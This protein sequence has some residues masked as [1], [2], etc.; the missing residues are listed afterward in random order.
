MKK[1]YLVKGLIGCVIFV[2][3]IWGKVLYVQRVHFMKAEEYYKTAEW[4]LA[5]REYDFAMHAYSPWSPYIEK[6]AERLWAI[7][8]IY[9]KED[10]PYWAINAFS[11]IRSSFY[12]SRSL[13][14]PGK[15]WID[16]CENK[17]AGLDVKI[18]IGEGDLRPEDAVSEEAK[19]LYLMKADREP[20]PLWAVLV[21][22]SFFGWIASVL[23]TI[24]RGFDESGKLKFRQA[25]YGTFFFV[26]SFAVWVISLYRA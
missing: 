19:F 20:V 15:D 26:A 13:F 22:V 8:Q 14:T 23:F 18:L 11:A 24:F 6:S 21:E 12:A 3:L 2:V 4:K 10:K 16:R 7:G 9:E 1:K 5:I 17:I 25:L